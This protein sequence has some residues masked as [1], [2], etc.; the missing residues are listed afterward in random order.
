[1]D[2]PQDARARPGIAA[3]QN[4]SV[5]VNLKPIAG[6]RTTTAL[7]TNQV[8]KEK[9]SEKVVTAQ[10]RQASAEPVSFQNVGS[11]GFQFWIRP[12]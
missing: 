10:V 4:S 9:I 7:I 6:M 11:S 5:V 8:A 3:S 12:W 2:Q 1:V